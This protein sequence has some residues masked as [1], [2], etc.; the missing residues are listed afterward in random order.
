MFLHFSEIK[1]INR[2][3]M[4]QYENRITMLARGV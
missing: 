1:L 3:E 4:I 2:K